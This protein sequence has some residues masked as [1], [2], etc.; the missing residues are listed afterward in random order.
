MEEKRKPVRTRQRYSLC[1][2]IH[3]FCLCFQK[4]HNERAVLKP[5]RNVLDRSLDIAVCK[6]RHSVL[7]LLNINRCVHVL[8]ELTLK[9]FRIIIRQLFA[10]RHWNAD[11]LLVFSADVHMNTN[12]SNISPRLPILGHVFYV[13]TTKIHICFH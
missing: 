11:V 9:V 6:R 3:V 8:Y 5:R 4:E 12:I 2:N 10:V 1:T 13:R 7:N